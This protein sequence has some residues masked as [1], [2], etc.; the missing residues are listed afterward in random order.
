[1]FFGLH[2]QFKLSLNPCDYN[3]LWEAFSSVVF[4]LKPV[5]ILSSLWSRSYFPF[6]DVVVTF[7]QLYA[8]LSLDF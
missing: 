2:S 8:E 6:G 3:H 5:Y 7:F 4:F 1:M